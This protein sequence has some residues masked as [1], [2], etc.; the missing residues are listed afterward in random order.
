MLHR[1]GELRLAAKSRGVLSLFVEVGVEQL[2]GDSALVAQVARTEDD[3][4]PAAAEDGLEPIATRPD[5]FTQPF[6]GSLAVQS[7]AQS[8]TRNAG[9][10]GDAELS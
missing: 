4:H 10:A 7:H 9:R 6:A 1:R 8:I 2:Q 5:D 3:P